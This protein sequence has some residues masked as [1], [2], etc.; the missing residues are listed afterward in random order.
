[1]SYYRTCP[2]CGAALDPGEQCD[3]KEQSAP[4]RAAA[5]PAW[6]K[7]GKERSLSDVAREASARG[8]TYG[9]YTAQVRAE[10]ERA[11]KQRAAH[12]KT[13]KNGRK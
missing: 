3:C 11:A 13:A 2:S 12:K 4:E 1:M 8:L 9:Q 6:A 10:A 5:L 7:G